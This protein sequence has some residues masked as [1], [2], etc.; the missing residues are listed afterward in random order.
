VINAGG[1][2]RRR[3][4]HLAHA[5]PHAVRPLRSRF[6]QDDTAHQ[7]T[8]YECLNS[9]E[10]KRLFESIHDEDV[11]LRITAAKFIVHLLFNNTRV[12]EVL[13]LMHDYDYAPEHRKVSS[14][15]SSTS[16]AGYN[17]ICIAAATSGVKLD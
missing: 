9:Q 13:A 10:I 8:I 6:I 4:V 12:I 1:G 7:Q 16:S 11:E 14:P 3:Q 17:P 15:S 2:E 5:Q